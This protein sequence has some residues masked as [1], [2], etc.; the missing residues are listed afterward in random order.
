MDRVSGMACAGYSEMLRGK[1][2]PRPASRK[3]LVWLDGRAVEERRFGIAGRKKRAAI[4][5]YS[6]GGHVVE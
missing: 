5:V 6:D 1:F 3:R 2:E 4:A